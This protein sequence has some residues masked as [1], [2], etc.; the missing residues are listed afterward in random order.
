MT[1]VIA[2][3]CNDVH[4][5]ACVDVCPV[6]AIFHEEDVPAGWSPFRAIEREFFGPTVSGLGAPGGAAVV[7]STAL[8]H[9]LVAAAP[10]TRDAA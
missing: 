4:D 10:Q 9:P 1:Y 5:R 6:M 3:P 8:D 7:G 2:E